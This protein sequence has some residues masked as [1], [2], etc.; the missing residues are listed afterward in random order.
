MFSF[1]T[2]TWIFFRA[3]TLD[4]ARLIISR[5]CTTAW[6]DPRFPLWMACMILAVWLYQLV[7]NS[8][9]PLRRVLEMAPV[10][11]GLAMLMVAYLVLVAQP[12]TKP[13]IYFQF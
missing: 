5:V 13:F 1:V 8:R 2:F 4:D 6:T 12:S 11:V 7:F 9:S 3:Q 10:R